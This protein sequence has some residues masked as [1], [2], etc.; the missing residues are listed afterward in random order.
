MVLI[1]GLGRVGL[2]ALEGFGIMETPDL[3]LG[4]RV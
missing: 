1:L 4:F 3:G 2:E